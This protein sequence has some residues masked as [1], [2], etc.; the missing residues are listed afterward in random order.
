MRLAQKVVYL[1]LIRLLGIV[2]KQRRRG[3]AHL[4]GAGGAH[5]QSTEFAHNY[6]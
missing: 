1:C 2:G 3:G 6:G 5:D 4:A